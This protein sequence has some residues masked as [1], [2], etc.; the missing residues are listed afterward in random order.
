MFQTIT[1]SELENGFINR[2][3]VDF[4]DSVRNG[5]NEEAIAQANSDLYNV[6]KGMAQA[7][8]EGYSL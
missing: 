2:E 3:F 5:T 8:K 6:C 1:E 7:E 4:Q